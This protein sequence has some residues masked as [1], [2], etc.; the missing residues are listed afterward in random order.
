MATIYID[1]SAS[2]NGNGSFA[3]P[4]NTWASVTWTTSNSYLQKAGTK[5]TAPTRTTGSRQNGITV[6]AGGTATA[7]LII[8]SYGEGAKPIIDGNGRHFAVYIGNYNYVT[9]DNIEVTNALNIGIYAFSSTSTTQTTRKLLNSTVHTI[10]VFSDIKTITVGSPTTIETHLPIS[11]ETSDFVVLVGVQGTAASALS[12]EGFTATRVSDTVFTI[13]VDT[14][15]LTAIGGTVSINSRA[16][17]LNGEYNIIDNCLIYNVQ[18][19]GIYNDRSKHIKITNNKIYN[20]AQGPT[21]SGDNIQLG[22]ISGNY[23]IQNNYL[24][25]DNKNCKQIIINSGASSS[26]ETGVISDNTCIGEDGGLTVAGN[27]SP[28]NGIFVDAP[29][30]IIQRNYV[31]GCQ[32]GIYLDSAE[33][34]VVSDNIITA[35]NP[36]HIAGIVCIGAGTRVYNNTCVFTGT[37]NNSNQVG[38]RQYVASET[39]TTI[40]NNLCI[41]YQTGL[42]RETPATESNNAVFGYSRYAVSNAAL[43]T[44]VASNVILTNPKVFNFT[45]KSDSP[46]LNTGL[47]VSTSHRDYG[48]TVRDNPPSIGAY[49][50]ISERAIAPTRGVR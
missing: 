25:H 46:L 5:W 2:T 47:F 19:D 10:G 21:G 30:T 12:A 36:A 39:N 15:G 28:M 27:F 44:E 41:G 34:C 32:Y 6:N 29:N 14:T 8:G 26:T 42:T 9:L 50:F 49:E 35:Q 24:R 13:A 18:D 37:S 7:P 1:P 11:V 48:N 45:L 22:G 23:L 16:V 38:I 17:C 4:Y 20:V 3:T 33:N 31:S 43:N 40:N